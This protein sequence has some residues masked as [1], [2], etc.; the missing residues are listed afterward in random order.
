MCV[1]RCARQKE[2]T[3]SDCELYGDATVGG[4][5]A[6]KQSPS[7][8]MMVRKNRKNT[9]YGGGPNMI[10]SYLSRFFERVGVMSLSLRGGSVI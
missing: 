8:F 10:Q 7:E 2:L 9:G 4:N 6:V 3:E 1:A 5:V